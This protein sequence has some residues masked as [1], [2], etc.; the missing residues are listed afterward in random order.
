MEATLFTG[1]IYDFLKPYA[2]ELKV[3]HPVMLKAISASKKKNDRDDAARIAD[4]LR[5]DLLPECYMAPQEIRELR[6]VLRYRTLMMHEAVKM[7]NKAAGLL[8]EVGAEYNKKQLH[9]RR[10]FTDLLDKIEDVPESVISMLRLNRSSLEMFEQVQKKLVKELRENKRHKHLQTV[11]IEAAK[12]APRRNSELAEVYMRELEK[13]NPNQATLA[14]A[15]KLV[16]Y[17]LAVD[18]RQT[19]FMAREEYLAA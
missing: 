9:S 18:K 10:Y 15:R 7:K 2:V 13:G 16:A 11:L 17:L 14:V 5:C 3:A 8:M 19:V 4:L 1:W 6:R 12:L